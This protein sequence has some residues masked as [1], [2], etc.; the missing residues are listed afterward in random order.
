MLSAFQKSCT[1]QLSDFV[2]HRPY[3]HLFLKG[4]Y[5]EENALNL[6]GQ[7]RPQNQHFVSVIDQRN[8]SVVHKIEV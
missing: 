4:M 3:C 7:Q 5:S 6:L 1:R 2:R 8:T